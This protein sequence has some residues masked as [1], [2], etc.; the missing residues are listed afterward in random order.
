[1]KLSVVIVNYNVKYYLEQCLLSV[2]R[3]LQGI[4]GEVWVVDNNSNDGS[5][6]YLQT[7]FPWVYYIKNQD[8][9]GFSRA[10]NQAIR[11]SRGE[12]I[13]LLNPDTI[14]GEN[15]LKDVITFMDSHTEAGG[16]GVKMLRDDGSFALESK[17]GVPTPWN[18]FCKMIGLSNRFP[19]SRIFGRY[20]MQFLSPHETAKIEILS[21]ACMVLRKTALDKVGLLDETFFMY[22]EDIDLS[23]RILLGGYHNYYLPTKILHYKGE[24]TQKTSFKYAITFHEAMH[25]FYSKHFGRYNFLLLWIIS[26]A[27][28]T[29]AIMSYAVRLC[30]KHQINRQSTIQYMRNKKFLLVGK[31][32]NLKAMED[33]MERNKLYHSVTEEVPDKDESTADIVLFDTDAFRFEEI[34]EWFDH[35]GPQ[36]SQPVIGTYI[37]QSNTVLTTTMVIR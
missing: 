17:R 4:N 11:Q 20:H 12:Y 10:N 9:V 31:G 25:I 23:Y 32:Q 26:L 15:T 14:L 16:L 3:A 2:E 27:I 1:M 13:I 21:G 19:K 7:K 18:S 36:K 33:I 6:E 24:S 28:Y 8:N 29:K 30:A 22:G 37:S 34:L 35:E 5:V